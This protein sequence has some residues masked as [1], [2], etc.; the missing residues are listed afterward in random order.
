MR[1]TAVNLA[2][3]VLLVAV[4]VSLVCLLLRWLWHLSFR[5]RDDDNREYRDMGHYDGAHVHRGGGDHLEPGGE[6]SAADFRDARPDG[7]RPVSPGRAAR[8]AQTV[9]HHHGARGVL[10]VNVL[11]FRGTGVLG[12][13]RHPTLDAPPA[14]AAHARH[15]LLSKVMWPG[16]P[17]VLRRALM[18]SHGDK[19]SRRVRE[20]GGMRR[21]HPNIGNDNRP[22]SFLCTF[23]LRKNIHNIE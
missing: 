14:A 13:V 11:R 12:L 16:I 9:V 20:N 5:N 22:G 19:A 3:G 18:R 4:V 8:P 15:Q 21:E 2:E 1:S 10:R 23:V 17:G 6:E 7:H